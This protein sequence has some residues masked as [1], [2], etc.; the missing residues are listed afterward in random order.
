MEGAADPDDFGPL[1]DDYTIR[2][3]L[4]TEADHDV[5]ARLRIVIAAVIAD[6]PDYRRIVLTK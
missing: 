3:L 6:D 2:V 1:E 4:R 5:W